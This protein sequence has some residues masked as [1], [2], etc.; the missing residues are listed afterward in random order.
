MPRD[1]NDQSQGI[2]LRVSTRLNRPDRYFAAVD[3]FQVLRFDAQSRFGAAQL[4][5]DLL[6]QV[7]DKRLHRRSFTSWPNCVFSKSAQPVCVRN[8]HKTL[9]G[10]RHQRVTGTSRRTGR[11][12]REQKRGKQAVSKHTE[13]GTSDL[14]S[15]VL[16][17]RPANRKG[18]LLPG[19]EFSDHDTNST[20]IGKYIS[21]NQ[22]THISLPG[23]PI[24]EALSYPQS[25]L[26]NAD[27]GGVVG[28]PVAVQVEVPAG[29]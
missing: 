24:Q 10:R 11:C 13:R 18:R 14:L 17:R 16:C 12:P 26:G 28:A 8:G 23:L 20:C 15:K 25:F 6:D 27:T 29:G 1:V 21:E 22:L 2:L 4:G 7:L 3:I 5:L 9:G 19:W